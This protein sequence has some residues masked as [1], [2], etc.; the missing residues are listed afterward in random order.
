MDSSVIVS[1]LNAYADGELE[2]SELAEAEAYIRARPDARGITESRR[3]VSTAVRNGVER[4]GAPD[5]LRARIVARV[6]E[7]AATADEALAQAVQEK[8]PRHR[9]PAYVRERI[10]ADVSRRPPGLAEQLREFLG[11]FRLGPVPGLALSGV[12][13]LALVTAAYLAIPGRQLPGPH[14]VVTVDGKVMCLDCALSEGRTHDYGEKHGH[15]NGLI[16]DDG[17]MWT[18]MGDEKWHPFLHDTGVWNRAVTIRGRAYAAASFLE[19][20]SL[21]WSGVALQSGPGATDPPR[22]RLV[23]AGQRGPAR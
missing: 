23:F 12:T 8:M 19:I 10:L 4:A 14:D 5:Y 17:T 22:T 7:S 1:L 13:V 11:R 6:E 3:A 9:A 15:R 21:E 16:A 18:I 2:G 20:D